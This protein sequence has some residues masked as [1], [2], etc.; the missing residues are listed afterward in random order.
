MCP[1]SSSCL[2]QSRTVLWHLQSA[3]MFSTRNGH[4]GTI[5]TGVPRTGRLSVLVASGVRSL[6]RSH[7][8]VTPR[9]KGRTGH[10]RMP[11]SGRPSDHQSAGGACRKTSKTMSVNPECDDTYGINQQMDGPVFAPFSAMCIGAR[12]DT[13]ILG[14]SQARKSCTSIDELD[15]LR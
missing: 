6:G 13:C 10:S 5:L 3:A 9:R 2:P 11:L 15:L 14:A 7:S 8:A 1:R 12:V 4:E